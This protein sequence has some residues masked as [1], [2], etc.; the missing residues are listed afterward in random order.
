M[1]GYE[2][3]KPYDPY[4]S[5]TE[6]LTDFD[7]RVY[8]SLAKGGQWLPKD[9]L[10]YLKE[11]MTIDPALI[12]IGQV[13]GFTQFTAQTSTVLAGEAT[14][15]ATYVDLGTVGPTVTGLAD[16]RY[17]LIYGAGAIKAASG[18]ALMSVEVNGVAA[19]ND[20]A[21]QIQNTTY[22]TGTYAVAKTLDAGGLN[23]VV[24]KYASTAGGSCEFNRRF[25]IA[26]KYAN[27]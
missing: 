16:G 11:R 7:R 13:V 26:L 1:S 14:A 3:E 24:A 12:P 19:S 21:V 17:L 6:P 2:A 18:S 8:A 15:S 9:F 23:T 22:V 20:D 10:T 4:Q 5:N 25:L 27:A